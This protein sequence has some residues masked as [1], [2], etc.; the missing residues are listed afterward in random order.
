MKTL[1]GIVVLKIKFFH[2]RFHKLQF[3]C[4]AKAKKRANK[5]QGLDSSYSSQ[6]AF[7]R[8]FIDFPRFTQFRLLNR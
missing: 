8:M 3:N 6:K 4:Y 7:L 1:V 5:Y 2:Q